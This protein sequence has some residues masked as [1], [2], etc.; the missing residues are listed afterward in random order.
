MIQD[1]E[2]THTH[3]L[4]MIKDSKLFTIQSLN[5]IESFNF[6]IYIITNNYF[7]KYKS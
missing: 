5:N 4:K 1:D 7:Y 6:S 3:T 2:A